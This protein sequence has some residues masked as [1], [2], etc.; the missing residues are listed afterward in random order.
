LRDL[1]E[2][3]KLFVDEYLWDVKSFYVLG[4]GM[5]GGVAME[6]SLL[7]PLKCKGVI[8]LNTLRPE[9]LPGIKVTSIEEL[10]QKF[11]YKVYIDKML[12][13][14][15]GKYYKTFIEQFGIDESN[16]QEAKKNLNIMK[17]QRNFWEIELAMHTFNI[18]EQL[19]DIS[20][21]VLLMYGANDI[22]F[23]VE[24]GIETLGFI[25]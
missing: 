17:Q 15:D 19:K 20:C 9:G 1:A 14:M 10:Q 12:K 6:L 21:K 23:P 16:I 2:D 24:D 13:T 8:L 3:M 5:G 18:K 7:M 25:G 11:P 22:F 4:H